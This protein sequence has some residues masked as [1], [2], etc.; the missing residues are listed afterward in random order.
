MQSA[1]SSDGNSISAKES[2]RNQPS[3]ILGIINSTNDVEKKRFMGLTISDDE[4]D[5]TSISSQNSPFFFPN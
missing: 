3:L 5:L 1:A 4:E 2:L